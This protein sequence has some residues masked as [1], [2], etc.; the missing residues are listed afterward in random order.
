MLRILIVFVLFSFGAQAESQQLTSDFQSLLKARK[1]SPAGEQTYCYLKDGVVLGKDPKRLQ[2]IASITKVFTT[3]FAS[4]LLDLHQRYETRIFISGDHLH[5]QGGRDPYWEEEKF[6]LLLQSLNQLGYRSFSKVTFDSNFLFTDLAFGSHADITASHTRDRLRFLLGS[7]GQAQL[8]TLWQG[9]RNFAAEEGINLDAQAP[10]FIATKIEV[11]DV[12][13]LMKENGKIFIHRSLPLHRI[14]KSMNVMSKN[15]VAQ[16]I[17]REASEKMSFQ[18]FM[19]TRGFSS[20]DFRIYNGSGLAVVNPKR[21]DNQATCE[22]VVLMSRSLE[23][24]LDKHGLTLTDL[25]AVSGGKDLGSLRN[26][27]TAHP[28]TQEAVLAKTGTLR[29]TS[30]L[31]GYLLTTDVIPFA[32]L[33]HTTATAEARRFQDDFV[34]RMFHH[35]EEP[36]PVSYEKISIFPWD[37]EPFLEEDLFSSGEIAFQG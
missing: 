20:S 26:R 14:I 37:G 13:P 36:I 30:S 24:G 4:E 12:S 32:I 25:M 8:R 17:F 11:S 21:V 5:I 19:N 29:H 16:N 18:E 9:I 3:Y 22:L 6:L 28:F 7:K 1:I 35:I 31:S 2:R 27:F 33:N 15:H 23:A 34:A 10:Q